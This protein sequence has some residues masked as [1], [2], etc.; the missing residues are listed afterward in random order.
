MET[1][2]LP[3]LEGVD[4]PVERDL[5]DF[6]GRL[7]GAIERGLARPDLAI[8]AFDFDKALAPLTWD[9]VFDRIETVWNELAPAT[10]DYR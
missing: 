4:R 10:D 6:V 3:R 2:A 8:E 5:P 7:T 1:V 9:A